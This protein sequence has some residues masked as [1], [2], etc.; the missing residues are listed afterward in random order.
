MSKNIVY[1][2]NF[3]NEGSDK[4]EEHLIKSFD[5][6]GHKIHRYDE[7][8]F[9]VQKITSFV[10][11]VNADMFLY[12]KGGDAIG[13]VVTQLV[14]LLTQLTCTKVCWYFDK[15]YGDR[16]HWMETIIPY[17][18]FV[19][20]TDETWARRNNYS[21]VY[22]LRQGIGKSADVIGDRYEND[23]VFLGS[24]Y[25]ERQ[26]FVDGLREVY[27]DRFKIINDKFNEDLIDLCTKTK[28]FVAPLFPQDNFYWSS[29]IYM[30][31]GSG[32]FLIHPRL[33]GLKEE[34]SAD[35][36]V[37]YRDG[38][39]LKEKIDFY[40]AN[41]SERIRIQ[42]AGHKKV[43]QDYTYDKRVESLMKTIYA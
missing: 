23:I 27:G 24:V 20:L 37:T 8:D 21:N 19:F 39:D 6:L 12:H 10:K 1:L 22:I 14:Q 5:K 32:G 38:L 34:F 3:S 43:I 31:L 15:V 16:T 4:T 9:N 42:K 40:L 7:R 30:I 36:L 35:E 17:T 13:V 41:D 2:A 26:K 29:R 18:D 28:I 25:G 11:E 33:E